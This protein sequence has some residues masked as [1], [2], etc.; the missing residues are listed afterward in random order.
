[1][2]NYPVDV[3]NSLKN[4]DTER[5]VIK[6]PNIIHESAQRSAD[7]QSQE[8]ADDEEKL[9]SDYEEVNKCIN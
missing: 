2:Q 4:E 8:T 3:S 5:K 6:M 9:H 1:M 7:L